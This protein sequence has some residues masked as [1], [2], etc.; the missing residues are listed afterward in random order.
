[1]DYKS[2]FRPTVDAMGGYTPGEQ[3][4]V[5][6]LI[7]LNTNENPYPPSPRVEEVLRDFDTAKLRLYPEPTADSL[8]DVIASVNGVQRENVIVGNG[9]D[10]ILTIIVRCFCDAK[11]KMACIDPTYSLYPVLGELQ[12]AECVRIELDDDFSLPDDILEQAAVANLLMFARPNAPTGNL[13]PRERVEEICA[14]FR[15]IVFI[16]E[17]YVDFSE[18][19]CLD[20]AMRYPNVIVSRTMSKSYAL[21]GVRLGY[22]VANAKI[23][24]GMMK[25]KD[26]YNVNMLTQRIAIEAFK[27]GEYLRRMVDKIISTRNRIAAALKEL[28]FTMVPSSTNFLFV[29]P[30]DGNGRLYFEELRKHNIIVRYFPGKKTGDYARISIGTDAEMDRVMEVTRSIYGA[31]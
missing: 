5:L 10:D 25:M 14:H 12:G 6:D 26:S 22:A 18:N 30:P 31:K 15:G 24:D 7:K 19:N 3:P 2:Y 23:I 8:R 1:M 21:A 20:L 11:R 29:S 16:D 27:D 13:F 28:G 9:S 4:K 17:A